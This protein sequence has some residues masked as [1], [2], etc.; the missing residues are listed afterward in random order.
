MAGVGK[1]L[2]ANRE[3]REFN[4]HQI[5]NYIASHAKEFKLHRKGLGKEECDMISFTPGRI[6]SNVRFAW[7]E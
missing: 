3:V 6:S 2:Q 7:R 4:S 1:T 5:I